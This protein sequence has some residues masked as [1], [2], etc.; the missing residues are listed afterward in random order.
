VLHKKARR[1]S[2]LNLPDRVSLHHPNPNQEGRS[3][4]S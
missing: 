4:W 1:K 3:D 2:N